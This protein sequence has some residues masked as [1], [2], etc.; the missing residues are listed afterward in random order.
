MVV[1]ELWLSQVGN[2]KK[3]NILTQFERSENEKCVFDEDRLAGKKKIRMGEEEVDRIVEVEE[4][5]VVF[6]VEMNEEQI[7]DELVDKGI[8]LSLIVRLEGGITDIFS[9]KSGHCQRK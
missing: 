8:E 1:S 7:E 2:L 9:A 3:R 6:E 5:G 4:D